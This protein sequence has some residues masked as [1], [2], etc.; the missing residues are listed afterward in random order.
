[1]T[2]P[3]AT[4]TATIILPQP[5]GTVITY[6]GM[7]S[8]LV[9]LLSLGW[10]QCN[11]NSVSSVAYPALFTAI[12]TTYGGDGNPNFNVPD[13]R[14]MFLRCLDTTGVDP[15]YQTRTSPIS[16]NTAVAG[17]VVGS[18]QAWQVQNHQHQWDH[19]FAS[20]T[21][22]GSDINVQLSL[23]SPT[24]PAPVTQPTT[25]VDGGG[26]ETRPCNVYAYFLIFAGLP[27]TGPQ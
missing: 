3:S 22:V 19:N 15:D 13:L 20:I 12:G 6:M 5:A 27:Q 1:M 24:A 11:G 9:G 4:A 8:T 17:P 25:N 10:L 21:W 14:G 26:N 16:G 2:L 7:Q 18:R 23:N